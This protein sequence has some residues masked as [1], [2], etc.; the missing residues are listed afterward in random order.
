LCCGSKGSIRNHNSSVSSGLAILGSSV[1][2][3]RLPKPPSHANR[4]C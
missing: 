4:F 3:Q 1:N 2:A